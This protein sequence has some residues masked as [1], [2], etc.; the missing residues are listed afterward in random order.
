MLFSINAILD[1]TPVATTTNSQGIS[2]PVFNTNAFGL[3]SSSK[4]NFSALTS[5]F[6]ETP[7]LLNSFSYT[8]EACLSN[9]NGSILLLI[10]TNDIFNPCPNNPL[11]ASIPTSPAPKT[12]TFL[13]FLA[14]SFIKTASSKFLKP[15]T[16]FPSLSPG[17]GGTNADAPLQTNNLSYLKD[18]PFD[19]SNVCSAS[20]NALTSKP[21]IQVILFSSKK[22]LLV[23]F[24]ASTSL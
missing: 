12:T 22:S 4:S 5:N 14:C 10:S 23:K 19:N 13:T 17:T 16:F 2:S 21:F 3:F 18:S 7:C 15:T 20:F 11:T 6:K 8:S 9:C 24:N 1:L